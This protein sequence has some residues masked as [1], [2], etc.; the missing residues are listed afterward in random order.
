MLTKK[1]HQ[2]LMFIKDHLSENGI[3]P[4]FEEMKE[5][6]GLHSKSGIHRLI[7]ALEERGFIRRLA[8]RARAL[9][10][11][12]LPEKSLIPAEQR[13]L[14]L[15]DVSSAYNAPMGA[16]ND[17]G[18]EIPMHGR[19]AAGMPVE[20]MENVDNFITVPPTML[21]AGDHFALE[22]DGDSMVELGILDGDT[23]IVRQ[24][25]NANNGDI[26]VALIGDE[27]ATLKTLH[28]RGHQIALKPANVTHSTQ[29]YP[30]ETVRIQGK[31]V[32]ILRK[33]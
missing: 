25:E 3:S 17:A 22:V 20:A 6:L 1:Q 16:A 10:I 13:N 24:V 30:A 32:G 21:G 9:E 14:P 31:L 2:L 8:H 4:S 11:I 33:Y 27:E 23:A 7:S 18:I 26:V 29:I 19:I 15:G 5:A 12:K 28:K